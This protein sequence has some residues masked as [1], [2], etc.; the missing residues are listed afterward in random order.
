MP[1]QQYAETTPSAG[2]VERSR[3]A[4]VMQVPVTIP[5]GVRGKPHKASSA[6]GDGDRLSGCGRHYARKSLPFR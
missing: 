6:I 4:R 1:K 3:Y 2:G 5:Y